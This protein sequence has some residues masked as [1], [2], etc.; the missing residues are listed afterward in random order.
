MK[1]LRS[2]LAV[3][4]GLVVLTITSFAIEWAVDPLLLRLFPRALPNA[5]AL[6]TNLYA[7]LF[8]YFYTGLSVAAGGYVTAWIAGRSPGRHAI[9]LGVVELALTIGAMEAAVVQ[10]PLRNWI[11]GIVM[12]VPAA[13]LGGFLRARQNA[14]R[15]TAAGAALA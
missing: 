5:S 7:S 10:T 15:A 13:W 2:V 12:V 4:A 1:I 9:A 3:V 14:R 11:I 6:N 8:M